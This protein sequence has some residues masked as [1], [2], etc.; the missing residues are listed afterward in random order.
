MRRICHY[1]T[2]GRPWLYARLKA[3]APERGALKL[4]QS[5]NAA[6]ATARLSRPL[7]QCPRRPIPCAVR[8]LSLL[9]QGW[10]GFLTYGWVVALLVGLVLGSHLTTYTTVVLVAAD[11]VNNKLAEAIS[12]ALGRVQGGACIS[13]KGAPSTGSPSLRCRSRVVCAVVTGLVLTLALHFEWPLSTLPSQQWMSEHAE[14]AAAFRGKPLAGLNVGAYLIS[15]GPNAHRT[16]LKEAL[17]RYG[18]GRDRVNIVSA[19]DGSACK[20]VRSSFQTP[21]VPWLADVFPGSACRLG[22]CWMQCYA[23]GNFC[24]PETSPDRY[25]LFRCPAETSPIAAGGEQPVK[26]A[27]HSPIEPKAIFLNTSHTFLTRSAALRELAVA[28]SH[29]R[30]IKAAFDAGDEVALIFEDDASAAL[31]PHWQNMGLSEV[32]DALPRD[33]HVIQ[34][35]VWLGLGFGGA[36]RAVDIMRNALRQGN[37][38][39]RRDA[40]DDAELWGVVAYAVSRAGMRELLRTHWRDPEAGS[41]IA[42]TSRSGQ[43]AGPIG[44]L[45]DLTARPLSDFLIYAAPN[46][47]FANRPLFAHQLGTGPH[48]SSIHSGHLSAHEMDRRRALHFFYGPESLYRRSAT[49]GSPT[50]WVE[51]GLAQFMETAAYFQDSSI[52]ITWISIFI[53]YSFH[54]QPSQLFFQSAALHPPC[55]PVLLLRPT[56]SSPNPRSLNRIFPALVA[57]GTRKRWNFS[58]WPFPLR[59]P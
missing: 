14:E 25:E 5:L 7:A 52:W 9:H 35:H 38:V 40:W 56:L 34:L 11:G 10:Q 39:S 20:P 53:S 48:S 23:D 31:I 37:L 33:W 3:P 59:Y 19:L 22:Q 58:S 44:P 27:N 15:M 50:L 41:S 18:L 54:L 26:N 6:P 43:Y 2:N 12:W 13:A 47:F 28:A 4:Q 8:S 42:Q 1:L 57:T 21:A 55:V 24:P 17:V 46:T 51:L 16:K 29:L 36:A 32:L 49:G 30:A 45:L